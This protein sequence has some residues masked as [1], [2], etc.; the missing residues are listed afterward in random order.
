MWIFYYKEKAKGVFERHKAHLVSDGQTQQV[1]VD[2]G[3]TFSSIVKPATIRTVLSLSLSKG[4]NIHQMDAKNVFL[5]G[6]LK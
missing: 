1:G 2:C 5:H 4:W 3:K 6:E